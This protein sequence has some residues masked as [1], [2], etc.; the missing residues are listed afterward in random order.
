[1]FACSASVCA[2]DEPEED[3]GKPSCHWNRTAQTIE[4]VDSHRLK[5]V[6]APAAML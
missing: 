6:S 3:L 2:E 4:R 5:S 1:M